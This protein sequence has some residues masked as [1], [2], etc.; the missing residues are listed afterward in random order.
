MNNKISMVVLI[1]SYDEC[2]CF[3][4]SKSNGIGEIF[5][6]PEIGHLSN[7]KYSNHQI[8]QPLSPYKQ[9]EEA[10]RLINHAKFRSNYTNKMY[11]ITYSPFILYCINNAIQKYIS[12]GDAE[13]SINPDIVDAYSLDEYCHKNIIDSETRLIDLYEKIDG[14]AERLNDYFDELVD[15][16][17]R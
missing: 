13:D 8:C 11:I 12:F 7:D 5:A 4:K 1:G 2:M 14:V 17:N 9:V 6:Y 16:M 15:I 10:I 3:F